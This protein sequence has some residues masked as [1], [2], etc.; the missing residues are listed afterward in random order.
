VFSCHA[1]GGQHSVTAGTP[2]HGCKV[3]LV[4]VAKAAKLLASNTSI[5]AR[6]LSK[7]IEVS[8]ETAWTLCHRLR[9]GLASCRARLEEGDVV[10][11]DLSV[12]LRDVPRAMPAQNRYHSVVLLATDKDF[13]AVCDVSTDRWFD[14]TRLVNSC[15]DQREIGGWAQGHVVATWIGTILEYTHG[16]VSVRWLAHYVGALAAI[17]TMA[18]ERVPSVRGTLT[19]V[20]RRPARGFLDIRPPRYRWHP[21]FKP[22]VAP[23]NP[24]RLPLVSLPLHRR[25]R[26]QLRDGYINPSPT[27]DR[28]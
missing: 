13:R 3:P 1:C 4:K 22:H 18:V 5:S 11:T 7:L 10:V 12:R 8:L 21:S 14:P 24:V 20:L 19:A 9:A 17:Q 28:R 15:S 23:L 27:P 25:Q 26:V 2:L 6:A 16:T